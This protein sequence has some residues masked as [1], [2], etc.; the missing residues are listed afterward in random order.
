MDLSF[1]APGQRLVRKTGHR[2]P[3][4][5]KEDPSP[6]RHE[7]KFFLEGDSSQAGNSA[8]IPEFI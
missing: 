4:I 1:L 6:M 8:E 5:R 2:A 7:N 3:I